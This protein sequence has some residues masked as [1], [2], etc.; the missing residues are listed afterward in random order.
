MFPKKDIQNLRTAF[1]NIE[2]QDINNLLSFIKGYLLAQNDENVLEYISLYLNQKYH[3]DIE[4]NSWQEQIDHYAFNYN[5]NWFDG[6]FHL[7]ASMDTNA[8]VITPEANSIEDELKNEEFKGK[9]KTD[10]QLRNGLILQVGDFIQLGDK[11]LE[12]YKRTKFY[13][14]SIRNPSWDLFYPSHK[15]FEHVKFYYEKEQVIIFGGVRRVFSNCITSIKHIFVKDQKAILYTDLFRIEIESALTQEECK[16][17]NNANEKIILTDLS[18]LIEKIN[19]YLMGISEKSTLTE[20]ISYW[21]FHNLSSLS[22]SWCNFTR[23]MNG[24]WFANK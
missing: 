4:F 18:S 8:L 3:I 5:L 12:D 10:I 11:I 2:E 9:S 24:I 23:N 15:D 1:Y 6:F 19:Y 16:I 13:D 17:L 14:A 22:K 7:M 20:L 21:C